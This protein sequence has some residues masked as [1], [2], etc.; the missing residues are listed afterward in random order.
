MPLRSQPVMETSVFE[1]ART[2]DEAWVHRRLRTIASGKYTFGGADGSLREP[3][4][5]PLAQAVH[6][7]SVGCGETI[8]YLSKDDVHSFADR[9]LRLLFKGNLAGLLTAARQTLL[10]AL[11]YDLRAVKICGS[12]EETDSKYSFDEMDTEDVYGAYRTYCGKDVY[13]YSAT[14]SALALLPVDPTSDCRTILSGELRGL[15]SMRS[16]TTFGN[17]T[18]TAPTLMWPRDNSTEEL[19]SLEDDQSTLISFLDLLPGTLAA[20]SGVVTVFPDYLGYGE[21]SDFD[22]HTEFWQEGYM[23]AAVLSWLAA[24]ETFADFTNGCTIVD[25]VITVAGASEGGFAAFPAA[26]AMERLG[27]RILKVFSSTPFFNVEEQHALKNGRSH[28]GLAG[29]LS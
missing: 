5:K 26:T 12:C 4:L 20:S 23:Q 3:L 9:Y 19:S 1:T 6:N 15:V 27:Y 17:E 28:V 11:E 29:T 7:P 14:H 25:N 13:G 22:R 16:L 8:G 10:G 18:S 2:T 24:I 21:S